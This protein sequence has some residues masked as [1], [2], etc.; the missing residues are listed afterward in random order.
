MDFV[1]SHWEHFHPNGSHEKPEDSTWREC[2]K[3]LLRRR[4]DLFES[5]RHNY[6][7]KGFWRLRPEVD[8][9]KYSLID[10]PN[11]HKNIGENNEKKE[12]F[13]KPCDSKELS[14][15]EEI[16]DA[17][18]IVYRS[19]SGYISNDGKPIELSKLYNFV[20]FS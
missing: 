5:S 1:I 12:S 13:Q 9:R 11:G 19:P 15:E 10:S 7:M 8:R 14:S 18:V 4:K 2:I 20:N 17:E 16:L 6:G 3:A